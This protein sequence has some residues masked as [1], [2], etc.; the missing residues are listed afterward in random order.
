ME[1]GG[2]NTT[3]NPGPPTASAAATATPWSTPSEAAAGKSLGERAADPATTVGVTSAGTP[4]AEEGWHDEEEQMDLSG[5]SGG[6]EDV[7]ELVRN[8]D[9]LLYSPSSLK[10]KSLRNEKSATPGK[11]RSSSTGITKK[12]G[13]IS[14]LP[15]SSSTN[16]DVFAGG[17]RGD[18][19][20]K[21][22]VPA[23]IQSDPSKPTGTGS[24]TSKTLKGGEGGSGSEGGGAPTH[25]QQGP[26]P[27]RK[28]TAM[29]AKQE[30]N[31]LRLLNFRPLTVIAG[32][33][34]RV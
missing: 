15:R 7:E 6:E 32:S 13:N 30:Q 16:D 22:S 9:G 28:H 1:E 34:Q 20:S 31:P 33:R 17:Y 12:L 8:A 27:S 29:C 26:N 19:K 24:V 10:E 4:S 18:P 21:E 25:L 5:G 3:N 14:I 23:R 2:R 11:I